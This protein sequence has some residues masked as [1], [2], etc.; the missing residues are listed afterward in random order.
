MRLILLTTIL[1]C[2][3]AFADP[4]TDVGQ[5]NIQTRI[6][7]TNV[8][9]QELIDGQGSSTST[10]PVECEGEINGFTLQIS[11]GFFRYNSPATL[12]FEHW[13]RIDSVPLI[14][15]AKQTASGTVRITTASGLVIATY[16]T[17]D[18]ADACTNALAEIF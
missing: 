14:Q 6:D 2:G 7:Q 9:L 5:G 10:P 18:E 4:A 16:A 8:L 15:T 17:V 3:A 12:P 13:R 1:W 11:G